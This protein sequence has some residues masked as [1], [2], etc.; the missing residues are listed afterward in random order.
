MVRDP[1][2]RTVFRSQNLVSHVGLARVDRS[3]V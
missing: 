3:V 2:L 1:Q